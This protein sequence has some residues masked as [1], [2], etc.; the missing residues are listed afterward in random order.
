[1]RFFL[2]LLLTM[3][4][5]GP[6]VHLIR[7]NFTPGSQPDGNTVVFDAP[8]GLVVVDT[9]RHAEHTQSI[10]DFAAAR[11]KKIRAVVNTH[12]HL[13]HIGGNAMLRREVPGLRVYATPALE[14]ALKGFLANYANQL[15]ELIAKTG[16]QRHRT[17]LA[18]I[19]SG[20][21][22][23]PD[24]VIRTS[25]KRKIAGRTLMLH[26]ETDAVTAGDIWILDPA[27][28]TLVAG[29]LVTLPFP[30]LDTACP[31]RWNDALQRIEA[32]DFQT[33][34]PGHGPPMT[35][36]QFTRYRTS[37]SA[38]LACASSERTNAQC[39][40]EWLRGIGDLVPQ[41]EHELAR[42]GLD[43]Y[44]VQHLRAKKNTCP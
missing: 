5:V 35:R 14:D 31:P 33:L 25:A 41:S 19:E 37:Y 11:G 10:L 38:L 2:L 15:R 17:E 43:Y 4:E 44:L 8:Q 34:V 42:Q 6:G 36:E 21:Q 9:G 26:V 1:M 30:F 20:R 27:T 12:W 28:K 39:A 3:T 7:G 13:D 23:A 24:E 32:T 16:E 18:L 40:D 22:L 29:D